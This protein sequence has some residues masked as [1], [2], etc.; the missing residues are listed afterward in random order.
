MCD[1]QNQYDRNNKHMRWHFCA[2][3][4][5]NLEAGFKLPRV[6]LLF[7]GVQFHFSTTAI[8]KADWPK[9]VFLKF[10]LPVTPSRC[11]SLPG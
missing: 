10:S 9:V 4:I 8:E 11:S 3:F 7:V 2:C 6:S 1:E 5:Q